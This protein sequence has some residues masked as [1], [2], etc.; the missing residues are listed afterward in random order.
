MIRDFPFLPKEQLHSLV[1]RLLG[2]GPH[3][4]QLPLLLP[5][6]KLRQ[7]LQ[8]TWSSWE[9]RHQAKPRYY[10]VITRAWNLST[11][12]S[13]ACRLVQAPRLVSYKALPASPTNQGMGFPKGCLLSHAEHTQPITQDHLVHYEALDRQGATARASLTLR[14]H[15]E[16]KP[17]AHSGDKENDY[18][19]SITNN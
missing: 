9:E 4:T 19:G 6:S 5:E 17:S 16:G 3:L 2:P 10:S 13:A 12:T 18:R 8:S 1:L 11:K 14:S 7:Y 15:T